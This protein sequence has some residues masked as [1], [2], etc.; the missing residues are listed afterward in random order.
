MKIELTNGRTNQSVSEAS[1][2]EKVDDE[3]VGIVGVDNSLQHVVSTKVLDV[4]RA[5]A[6]QVEDTVHCNE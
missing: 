5:P 6:K 3:L 4:P 1:F 2:L